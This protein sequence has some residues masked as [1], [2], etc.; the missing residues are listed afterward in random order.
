MEHGPPAEDT[1]SL[2]ELSEVLSNAE[3]T[4]AEEIER[5]ADDFEIAPPAEA[6]VVNE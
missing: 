1:L 3:D 5:G 6:D 4:T 2:G